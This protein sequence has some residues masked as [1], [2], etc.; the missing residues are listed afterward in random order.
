MISLLI[1][2]LY[3]LS[4]GTLVHCLDKELIVHKNYHSVFLFTIYLPLTAILV[5][6]LCVIGILHST[7]VWLKEVSK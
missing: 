2:V 5:V 4:F 6:V 7:L 3:V 1:L